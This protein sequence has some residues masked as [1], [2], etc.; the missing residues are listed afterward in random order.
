MPET[1]CIVDRFKPFTEL[2]AEEIDLLGQLE[3]DPKSYSAGTVLC[4]A[5]S[6]AALLFTLV[7]GWAGS[8]RHFADGRRQV[9]DLYLPGQIMRL[10]ELG[11]EQAHSDLVAFTDIVACPFPRATIDQLLASPRLAAALLLTLT[12]EQGLLTE[13]ITNIARRPALQRV[14]H[15]LLEIRCRLKVEAETFE[16]PLT[17]ELIGDLL[18]LSSVHVSRTLRRLRKLGLAEMSDSKVRILDLAGL[19]TQSGFRNDY[20]N[21]PGLGG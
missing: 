14:A 19:E 5:G 4:S 9:L 6:P 17:Q 1:S 3:L 20:L 7:E 15:F 11:S 21:R 10:R 16:L 18:G 8:V 2:E 13:R 12:A